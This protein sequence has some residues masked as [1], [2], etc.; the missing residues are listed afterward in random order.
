MKPAAPVTNARKMHLFQVQ[1]V[2]L[3]GLLMPLRTAI[4]NNL[5]TGKV[6]WTAPH[7]PTGHLIL[8]STVI[9]STETLGTTGIVR[10][11]PRQ[12]EVMPSKPIICR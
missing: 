1:M 7:G 11:I 9:A 6:C 5:L 12:L 4:A 3:Q 8:C 10:S 2:S